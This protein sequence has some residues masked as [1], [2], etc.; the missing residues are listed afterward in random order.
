MKFTISSHFRVHISV[1]LSAFTLS[2]N[3]YSSLELFYYPKLKLSTPWIPIPHSLLCPAPGYLYPTL[4]FYNLTTL[5]SSYK[6]NHVILVYWWLAYLT[7]HHGFKV[8]PWCS[9]CQ[10]FSPSWGL[11]RVHCMYVYSLMY[12][13]YAS[14]FC[15]LWIL[16][17]G[18]QGYKYLF[19]SL[20]SILLGIH[21]EVDL[22]APIIIACIICSG[23]AI[24][25]YSL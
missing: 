19:M 23:I 2:R 24:L 11:P 17:L 10:N 13:W 12:I 21:P 5:T 20:L 7:L 25:L 9:R 14:T 16:L 18:T 4:C 3:H 1:A 6:W 22:L 15:L 8:H